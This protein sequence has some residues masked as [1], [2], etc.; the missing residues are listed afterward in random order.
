MTCF[1][2]ADGTRLFFKD[3]G[4]GQ[5]IPFAHGWPLSSGADRLDADVLSFIRA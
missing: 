5:P 1:T 4:A 3:W 2:T